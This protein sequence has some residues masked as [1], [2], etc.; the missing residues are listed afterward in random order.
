MSWVISDIGSDATMFTSMKSFNYCG[1]KLILSSQYDK[2]TD[3]QTLGEAGKWRFK[4]DQECGDEGGDVWRISSAKYNGFVY[5]S[6]KKTNGCR[7]VGLTTGDTEDATRWWMVVRPGGGVQIINVKHGGGLTVSP[8][9]ANDKGD[10]HMCLTDTPMCFQCIF[11][12]WP[13]P[14]MCRFEIF[15]ELSVTASL[16]DEDG[17][18]IVRCTFPKGLPEAKVK[19]QLYARYKSRGGCLALFDFHV[20]YSPVAPENLVEYD[21]LARVLAASDSGVWVRTA[22]PSVGESP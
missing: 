6:D 19:E 2:E 22:W 4:F 9:P 5:A 12:A 10:F 15:E 8:W 3:V 1:D 20:T 18:P 11:K 13:S 14:L 17:K 21:A 16:L 7:W